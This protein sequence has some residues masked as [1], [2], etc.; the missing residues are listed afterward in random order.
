LR[1]FLRLETAFHIYFLAQQYGLHREAVQAARV[2]LRIPITIEDLGD[3]LDFP[4]MTGTYLHEL[5]KY[6]KHVRKELEEAVLEFGNSGFPDDVYQLTCLK[7]AKYD[8]EDFPYW[9]YDYI[10]SIAKT[11]HLFDFTE[12]EAA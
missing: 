10:D 9:L 11:P 6:H 12:F 7:R 2:T 8:I 1:H 3:K 5:W 4:G